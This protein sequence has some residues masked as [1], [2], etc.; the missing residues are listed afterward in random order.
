V[1]AAGDYAGAAMFGD[2]AAWQCHAARAMLRGDEASYRALADWCEPEAV[3]HAAAARWIYGDTAAALALASTIRTPAAQRFVAL[4]RQPRIRVLAQL[5]WQGGAVTDLRGGIGAD[6]HFEV[7]SIGHRPGDHWHRPYAGVA[8]YL[9]DGFRP[10]FY[11]AAMVEWQHVLPDLAALPCPRFG[12]IADH[13]LHI[14]T[15]RPWLDLFDELC[16]TDRTEWL[17]VQGLGRGLVSSCPHV[18]GLPANLPPLAG[19]ERPFD[20]FVS[21]TLLDPYHPDKAKVMHELLAS[22]GLGLRLVRGFAGALAFHSMLGASKA[23]FTYVRRPGAMPTR[24]MESLA[25]GSALALQEESILNLWVGDAEGVTTWNGEPGSLTR[26]LRRLVEHWEHYGPAAQRG[27]ALLRREFTLARSASRYFRFLAFRAATVE[28]TPLPAVATEGW[29]QKRLCVSRTWLPSEAVVRRRS[30]QANFRRLGALVGKAP[31]PG[32]IVDMARELLC[33]FV[34]YEGSKDAEASER[35]FYDDAVG[36]LEQCERLFPQCLAARFL[37]VRAMFHHGSARERVIALQLAFETIEGDVGRW[38]IGPD[39]DVMPFDFHAETFNYRDYLD[40]VARSA[41]GEGV[42]VDAL[43]RLVLAALAGYVARASGQLRFHA[44][45]CQ[46]DP[47]FARYRLD[48]ARELG[49]RP[50]PAGRKA[51]VAM[52]SELAE[53]SAEFVAAAEALRRGDGESP[54]LAAR[55]AD[56]V[57]RRLWTDTIDTV[58]TTKD[59]VRCPPLTEAARQATQNARLGPRLS[60]LL[61]AYESLGDLVETMTELEGQSMRAALEWVVAATP[62]TE[63]LLPAALA[64]FGSA[65]R[66]VVVPTGATWPERLN[67]CVAAASG[68]FVTCAMPFDRWQVDAFAYLVDELLRHPSADAA[69]A[70]EGLAAAPLLRFDRNACVAVT[71]PPLDVVGSLGDRQSMGLHA[72]WRRRLHQLHGCFDP[73]AGAGAEYAFWL[74]LAPTLQVRRLPTVLTIGWL[75]APWRSLRQPSTDGPRLAAIRTRWSSPEVAQLPWRGEATLPTSLLS[76]GIVAEAESAAHLGLLPPTLAI[77]FSHLE[78]CLGTALLHG[79]FPLAACLL[80]GATEAAPQLLSGWMSLAALLEATGQPGADE[81][82]E[83]AAAVMPWRSLLLQRRGRP[84][85]PSAVAA[86]AA[87]PL[88]RPEIEPCLT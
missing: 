74:R 21:G 27:A 13:D 3:L 72:V 40:L 62:A 26:A 61:P 69:V 39:D 54:T 59:V 73:A 16:V 10:D 18:F 46:L 11:L 5:P 22:Q 71:V 25:L 20:C 1:F 29:C 75:R 79:D 6:P 45:A 49:R 56:R 12:H 47:G 87:T 17:D 23:S 55:A 14:Q 42:P 41:K 64:A 19:I 32:V 63:S 80:R 70:G 43:R 83:R 84:L 48:H 4:L 67:A 36:L 38:R 31:R 76:P 52:L 15:I 68:E 57:L 30:M 77:E 37:R 78:R 65:V 44:M 35:K 66:I 81:V 34:H 82:L 85:T 8:E 88:P 24:G 53:G 33:E 9:A 58:V 51:A 7:R 86:P 60:V 2:E 28:R 50:E